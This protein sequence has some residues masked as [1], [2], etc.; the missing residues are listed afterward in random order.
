M[1]IRREGQHQEGRHSS[2]IR[3]WEGDEKERARDEEDEEDEE[4]GRKKKQEKE[5]GGRGRGKGEGEEGGGDGGGRIKWKRNYLSKYEHILCEYRTVYQIQ[6]TQRTQL[7]RLR[8]TPSPLIV[9]F[10]SRSP[11]D[12][13]GSG[14]D[15]PFPFSSSSSA[16]RGQPPK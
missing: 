10:Q 16:H 13:F 11:G 7:G 1:S 3:K 8:A 6:R 2:S 5:V 12:S 14:T 15:S 9:R 4:K